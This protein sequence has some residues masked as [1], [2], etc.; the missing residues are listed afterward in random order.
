M[1][2][3]INELEFEMTRCRPELTPEFFENVEAEVLAAVEGE[4]KEQLQVRH[5]NRQLSVVG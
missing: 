1:Q 4:R 2:T 3:E 5:S